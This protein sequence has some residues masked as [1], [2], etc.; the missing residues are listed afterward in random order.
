[1]TDTAE[2]I[3]PTPERIAHAMGLME[4]PEINQRVQ[5]RAYQAQSIVARMH[6]D[7]KISDECLRA[8]QRFDTD[9]SVGHAVPS[10]IAGYGERIASAS[11]D[12][13]EHAEVRKIVAK[14]RSDQALAS[15][16]SPHGQR[17]LMMAVAPRQADATSTLRPYTLEEIG[18]ACSTCRD[19]AQAMAAGMVTLRDALYQL[20]LHYDEG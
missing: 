16:G 5:R 3:A 6:T 1:M 11:S 15:I 12:G 14:Q 18:R 17:A 7:G 10:A 2:M 4:A 8:F 9:W 19:R 13:G 20:H